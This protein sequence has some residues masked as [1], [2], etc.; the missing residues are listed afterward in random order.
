M[1]DGATPD[2]ISYVRV[3]AWPPIGTAKGAQKLVPP[4]MPKGIMSVRQQLCT[5]QEWGY[6]YPMLRQAS[7]RRE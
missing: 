3:H 2:A 7:R 6:I 5:G 1:A 4:T